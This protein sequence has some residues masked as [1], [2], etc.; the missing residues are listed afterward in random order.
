MDVPAL[1]DPPVARVRL[2]SELAEHY[3]KLVTFPAESVEAM[4]DE[5]YVRNVVDCLFRREGGEL[6]RHG[7]LARGAVH[8]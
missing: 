5:Q 3:K 7:L 6:E 1:V 4:P 8:R 2:F